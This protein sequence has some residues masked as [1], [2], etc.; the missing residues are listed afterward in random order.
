MYERSLLKFAGPYFMLKTLGYLIGMPLSG[1]GQFVKE[2]SKSAKEHYDSVKHDRMIKGWI[3]IGVG[4][5]F[6]LWV[7]FSN[8]D[9]N[10]GGRK[11]RQVIT[12]FAA[13]FSM[14]ILYESMW[15]NRFLFE[16]KNVEDMFK[17][18]KCDKSDVKDIKAYAKIYQRQRLV[19]NIIEVSSICISVFIAIKLISD[20]E[21]DSEKKC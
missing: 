1:T 14:S 5:L 13:F 11:S 12:I 2:L 8:T 17:D 21:M 7:W 3:S 6:G 4:L 20:C 15:Q 9:Y 18:G 19:G 10:A 16:D